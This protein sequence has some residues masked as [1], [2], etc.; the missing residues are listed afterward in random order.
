MDIRQYI[1]S[2][3]LESY[4]LGLSSEEEEQEVQQMKILY[5]EVSSALDDL[6]IVI[7]QYCLDSAVPPP[8]GTWDL[9]QAR[10]TG[11]DLLKRDKK[12]KNHTKKEAKNDK[13]D[14]LEVEVSDSF[15]RVHKLWR[16]AFFVVFV[17]S[18][19]FLI[20]GLYYYFKSDSQNQEIER[21][22]MEIQQQRMR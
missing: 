11:K 9:I 22:K 19:I 21:L 13:S 18:K 14:Y 1:N 7:E 15:I 5:P 8:P 20:A 4:L 16:I 12:D 10:T 2:G 6:E 17:L 3:V